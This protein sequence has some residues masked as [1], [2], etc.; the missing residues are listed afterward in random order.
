LG[1]YHH[2][3]EDGLL[4]LVRTRNVQCARIV[5]KIADERAAAMS[6]LQVLGEALSDIL[7]EQRVLR[8]TLDTAARSF[9]QHERRQIEF[10]ELRLFPVASAALTPKDLKGL[11]A[12]LKKDH[13]SS[14]MRQLIARLRSQRRW[15]VRE[16]M[17]DH[18][19]RGQSRAA[20]D[21]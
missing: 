18:A 14:Y 8:R 3:K 20:G 19:E 2:S 10:E 16:A 15:I 1:K 7:N 12:R 4:D 9:I 17:A 21:K 13:I 11:R 6:G 5:E